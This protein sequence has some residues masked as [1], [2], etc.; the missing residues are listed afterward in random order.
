MARCGLWSHLAYIYIYIYTNAKIKKIMKNPNI[1]WVDRSFTNEEINAY[2]EYYRNEYK[3]GTIVDVWHQR[4]EVVGVPRHSSVLVEI[5][6]GEQHKAILPEEY[7]VLGNKIK[8]RIREEGS[9]I[10]NFDP[11]QRG[12]NGGWLVLKQHLRFENRSFASKQSA[13]MKRITDIT[14]ACLLLH[15]GEKIDRS[16]MKIDEDSFARMGFRKI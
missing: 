12:I 5:D 9:V 2:Q 11:V 15:L 10:P 6:G 4:K 7:A 8:Y 3:I 1:K 13:L 16:T 14:P